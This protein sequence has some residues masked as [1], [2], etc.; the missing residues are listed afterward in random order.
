MANKHMERFLTS[1]A[2]RAMQIKPTEIPLHTYQG[3]YNEKV[4]HATCG[5]EYRATECSFVAGDSV[6]RYKYPGKLQQLST[7]S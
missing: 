2:S 6:K 1:L 3:G 7:N 4:C 5:Q